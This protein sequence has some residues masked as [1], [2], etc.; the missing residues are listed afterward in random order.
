MAIA[1]DGINIAYNGTYASKI[2]LEPLFVSDMME[3]ATVIPNVKYKM[4]MNLAG[5]LKGITAVNSGCGANNC[6]DTDTFA[7]SDK[8]LTTENVSVKQEQCWNTFKNRVIRESYKAGIN[9][10]DLTGTELA[11]VIIDRIRTGIGYDLSRNMWG[12][13][14][15]IA[16]DLNC[17]YSSMGDGLFELLNAGSFANSGK[18]QGVEGA[19]S[20]TAATASYYTTGGDISGADAAT[21]LSFVFENADSTLQRLP[22]ADKCIFVTANVYYGWYKALTQVAQ[23]GSV[24]A[25]HSDAQSG[26]ERLFFRGVEIKPMWVWD[27]IFTATDA[28]S[29]AADKVAMLVDVDDSSGSNV[30]PRNLAIY[31]AKSNLFV[32]TDVNSPETELRMFYDPA[33]DKMLIR[34]YFTMGFQYGFNSLVYGASLTD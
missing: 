3:Y 21:L 11:N 4:N 1:T 25:G 19:L 34:S 2:L 18:S 8:V 5:T 6:T 23:A 24:N 26:K 12:G 10:P 27:E 13:L 31:A 30:E 7:I 14:S 16:G 9:M 29:D 20:S 32:G 22:A 28:S 15:T 17:T 33:D